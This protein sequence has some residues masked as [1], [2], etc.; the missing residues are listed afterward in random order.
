MSLESVRRRGCAWTVGWRR[1]RRDRGESV[2]RACPRDEDRREWITMTYLSEDPT[3]LAGGLLLVAGGFV[4]ALRVTQ[5]G[6]YL[7]RAVIAAALAAV[8]G[9]GRMGV[10]DRQRADRAGGLRPAAGGG[11]LGRGGRAAL[12]DAGRPVLQGG[13]GAG[14]RGDAGPDPGQPEPCPVRLRPDQRPGDQ[15]G[16]AIAARDGRVPRLRQGD[17]GHLAGADGYRHGQFG[18]VA[19]LAGDRA[20][21]L[22]S[23][24]DHPDADPQRSPVHAQ[25]RLRTARPSAIG[26]DDDGSRV[27]RKG[28][29]GGHARRSAVRSA[30]R[31][32]SAPGAP[33]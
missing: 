6:K 8:G 33:Q 30:A 32:P 18:L 12:H 11:E 27:R 15:R 7:V 10:G 13:H 1:R 31:T 20:G 5:Q 22:E 16:G 29:R 19:G 4:V 25:R 23:E 14:R 17:A 28:G 21:G 24:P 2:G 9:G 3:L 26:P